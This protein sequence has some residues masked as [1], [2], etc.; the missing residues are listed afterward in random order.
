M[1]CEACVTK[2]AYLLGKYGDLKV[3]ASMIPMSIRG[4]LTVED[5]MRSNGYFDRKGTVRDIDSSAIQPDPVTFP[6]TPERVRSK[7]QEDPN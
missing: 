1:T 6:V 5:R 4:E 7:H 3:V 2:I